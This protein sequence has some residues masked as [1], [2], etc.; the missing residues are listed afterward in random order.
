MMKQ[1]YDYILPQHLKLSDGTSIE[2]QGD[3]KLGE[4]MNYYWENDKCIF[5]KIYFRLIS[6]GFFRKLDDVAG[7]YKTKIYMEN[8]DEPP[9]NLF[10]GE[11]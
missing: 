9:M 1:I 4:V 2:F 11:T 6:D 10:L 3:H 8:V 5:S 7:G